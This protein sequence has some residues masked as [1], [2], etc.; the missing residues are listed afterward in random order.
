LQ[1]FTPDQIERY[2]RCPLAETF[3]DDLF[4]QTMIAT[5]YGIFQNPDQVKRV[6]TLLY[7]RDLLCQAWV[8]QGNKVDWVARHKAIPFIANRIGQVLR[9]YEFLMPMTKIRVIVPQISSWPSTEGPNRE[10]AVEY[11]IARPWRKEVP[12]LVV[13]LR[14]ARAPQYWKYPDYIALTRWLH[15]QQRDRMKNYEILHVPILNGESWIEKDLE[16]PLVR[17]QV[18]TIL[19]AIEVK[20]QFARPGAHCEHC[21][22]PRCLEKI[23]GV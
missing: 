19:D 11:A 4:A 6:N 8:A 23:H 20:H 7:L 1:V 5:V 13:S 12:W 17:R 10:I 3:T 22:M 2:L 18:N 9:D 21:T 14:R 16:L 15:A